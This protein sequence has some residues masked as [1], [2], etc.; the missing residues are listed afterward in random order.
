[1]EINQWFIFFARGNCSRSVCILH[2]R[3][4]CNRKSWCICYQFLRRDG[5][6]LSDFRAPT[7]TLIRCV[8]VVWTF[9]VI[10]QSMLV[11]NPF[12]YP[13]WFFCFVDCCLGMGRVCWADSCSWL[14]KRAVVCFFLP[15]LCEEWVVPPADMRFFFFVLAWLVLVLAICINTIALSLSFLKPIPFLVICYLHSSSLACF[16]ERRCRL[17][18]VCSAICNN[19]WCW[20]I[21]LALGRC[22]SFA[23]AIRWLQ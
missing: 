10:N 21:A 13:W 20:W 7:E 4:I 6:D 16:W 14:R 12:C 2:N 22:L 18:V 17:W 5:W 19:R 15:Y 11:D 3:M 23:V 1:M 8:L 9:W